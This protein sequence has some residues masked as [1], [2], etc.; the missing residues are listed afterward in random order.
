[1]A[2]TPPK[3]VGVKAQTVRFTC[4]APWASKVFLVGTFNGWSSTDTAMKNDKVGN[5]SV[6][7]KL[8][9][10]RYEFKFIVDGCWC[11]DP[12]CCDMPGVHCPSSQCVQNPFGSMNR[13]LEVAEDSQGNLEQSTKES[14]SA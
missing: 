14:C 12:G 2:T 3:A 6:S 5:W 7:L 4:K 1:M 11:C 13:V 9:P 10:G 8:A